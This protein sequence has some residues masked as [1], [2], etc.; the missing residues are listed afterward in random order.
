MTAVLGANLGDI[1]YGILDISAGIIS[2]SIQV[3]ANVDGMLKSRYLAPY[4]NGIYRGP[5][6]WVS[7]SPN[8]IT[9]ARAIETGTT[10]AGIMLL[11]AGSWPDFTD[12]VA[13]PSG[14]NPLVFGAQ[15]YDALTA[16]RLVFNWSSAYGISDIE[17]EGVGGASQLS[18]LVISGAQRNVNLGAGSSSTRGELTYSVIT[19]GASRTIQFYAGVSGNLVASWTGALGA[20]AFTAS[21]VAAS[22]LTVSGVLTYTQDVSPGETRIELMWPARYNLYW[23]LSPLTF[24]TGISAFVLDSGSTTY[25]YQSPSQGN[26]IWYTAIVP[27]DDQGN[28]NYG[29]V[30]QTQV[31]LSNSPKPVSGVVPSG[32][33][34]ALTLNWVVA[35]AG[36]FYTVYYSD[37]SNEINFG[38]LVSPTPIV[39]GI[40]ATSVT[41]PAISGY[42]PVDRSPFITSMENTIDSAVAAASS[43]FNTSENAFVASLATLQATMVSAVEL[44]GTQVSGQVYPMLEGLLGV[45]NSV[46]GAE[47]VLFS[48]HLATASWQGGMLP[49]WTELITYIGSMVSGTARYALPNGVYP[50]PIVIDNLVELATPVSLPG[51]VRIVV[52]ATDG[53]GNQE[54]HDTELMVTFNPDGTISL[55]QPNIP[56]IQKVTLIGNTISV[57]ASVSSA[58]QLVPAISLNLYASLDGGAVD[59]TSPVA[60]VSLPVAN[61]FGIQTATLTWVSTGGWLNLYVAAVSAAGGVSAPSQPKNIWVASVVSVPPVSDVSVIAGGRS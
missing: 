29:S 28:P 23:S 7:A 52:R 34:S 25:F 57:K 22:G 20:G 11:D 53:A 46:S 12:P 1:A 40:D 18:A 39:T 30:V 14:I 21:S 49:Y 44:Y 4:V 59:L 60:S 27:V 54:M 26:G 16:S 35:Q 6:V 41:L 55:P 2:R 45:F 15:N 36:C 13:F 3:T 50:T 24:P 19:S 32:N 42:A 61:A 5:N 9:F 48:Q 10:I 31:L 38:A 33:A 43:A 51:V 17:G 8:P 56:A 58:K 37:V 47:G